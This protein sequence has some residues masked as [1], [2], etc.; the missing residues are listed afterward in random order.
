MGFFNPTSAN[1]IVPG[2]TPISGGTNTRVLFD[3][4]GFVGE[5]AGLTYTKASGLLASTAMAIGGATIGSNALAVTGTIASS[6]AVI[7]EGG[8]RSA[9]ANLAIG[10]GGSNYWRVTAGSGV[11]VNIGLTTQ[12]YALGPAD[13]TVDISMGRQG[14]GVLALNNDST[15]GVTLNVA[16]DSTL[17]LFARDGSTPAALQTGAITLSSGSVLQLGSTR[18]AG[19]AVQGGTITIKDASG[20]TVTLLTT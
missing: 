4:N 16:T 19:A 10:A 20:S 12:T 7:S 2:T 6:G 11:L 9:A 3:D 1:T 8:I 5:S 18:S 14:I 17:K 15:H 13:G